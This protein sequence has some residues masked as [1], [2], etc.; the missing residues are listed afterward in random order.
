VPLF[1]YDDAKVQQRVPVNHH[2]HHY[3][4]LLQQV[5][6]KQVQRLDEHLRPGEFDL[7]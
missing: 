2:R 4:L 7:R 5:V 3:L 1:R 6:E